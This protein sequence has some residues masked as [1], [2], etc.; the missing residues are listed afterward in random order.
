[1]NP[2]PK[3][4]SEPVGSAHSRVER[5]GVVSKG[6]YVLSNHGGSLFGVAT[7]TIESYWTYTSEYPFLWKLPQANSKV[8]A[9]HS[10]FGVDRAWGSGSKSLKEL[11][12]S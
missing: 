8:W 11:C 9:W 1:M 4:T 5:A 6:T 7:G 12:Q 2:K 3:H 10:G